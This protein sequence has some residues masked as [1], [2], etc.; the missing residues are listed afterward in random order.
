MIAAPLTTPPPH[1][2]GTPLRDAAQ[3]LHR[4]FVAEMLKQAKLTQAL[5]AGAGDASLGGALASV[6]LDRI[7]ADVA[8][9]QP[10]LTDSLY[11]ALRRAAGAD[12]DDAT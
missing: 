9:A 12:G 8:D 5:G 4:Q 10:G 1:I 2:P 11:H 6:A 7:A 3:A